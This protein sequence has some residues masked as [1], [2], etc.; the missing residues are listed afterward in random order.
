MLKD[1]QIFKNYVIT[2]MEIL[3]HLSCLCILEVLFAAI[4]TQ[5]IQ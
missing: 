4:C 5:Q 3:T 2:I 1:Q